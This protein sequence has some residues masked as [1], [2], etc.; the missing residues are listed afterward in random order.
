MRPGTGVPQGT[1]L[2]AH[3]GALCFRH[4]AASAAS[5]NR[6]RSRLRIDSLKY[7]HLTANPKPA[8]AVGTRNPRTII[9]A[10]KTPATR[11]SGLGSDEPAVLFRYRD[12]LHSGKESAV[13]RIRQSPGERRG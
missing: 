4:C 3:P 8:S 5:L 6:C 10:F 2:S 13:S 9:P 12:D 11:L 1:R 7:S